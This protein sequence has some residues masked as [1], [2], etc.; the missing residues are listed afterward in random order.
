MSG[1]V[2]LSD[3][4][5]AARRGHTSNAADAPWSPVSLLTQYTVSAYRLSGR[6]GTLVHP[7]RTSIKCT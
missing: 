3:A 2:V 7:S 1:D 4:V 6:K 5:P